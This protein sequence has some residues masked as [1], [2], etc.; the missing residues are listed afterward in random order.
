VVL[1][2]DVP[3]DKDAARMAEELGI[4]V[5]SADI[6][7]HLFDA[8]TK[9]N[10]EVLEARR[11]D[12]APN[13]VWPCRLKILK[14]FAKRDP[15]IVGCDILEGSLR[16]G[17]PIC[18]VKVDAET[19]KK[20]IIKLGKVTGLEIN[21]KTLDI[22]KKSQVGAGVAV[23]IECAV[24]ET[25]RLFGRHFDEKDELISLITRDSIDTLKELFR[26]DATKE[27]WVLIKKLKPV[28]DIP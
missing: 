15:I 22:V 4:K 7:Y 14:C 6:I 11:K 19:K 25:A 9:H 28:L 1:A 18:V 13:A 5:F 12:S 8:F 16:V 20:D 17:T 10:A 2:F 23:K 21:H 24:Y 27:D 26:A 3:I